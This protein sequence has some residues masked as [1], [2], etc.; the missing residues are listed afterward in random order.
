MTRE[1]QRKSDHIR[2]SDEEIH[3]MVEDANAREQ[4]EREER[5]KFLISVQSEGEFPAPVLAREYYDEAR[6]C[7]LYGAF[8]STILMSQLAIEELLKNHFRVSKGVKGCLRDE[9][10]VDD[11]YL[12]DLV[13][14][15]KEE[16]LIGK[17]EADD[18][19]QIRKT[20]RNPYTHVKDVTSP[21]DAKGKKNQS[22]NFFDQGLK[23]HNPDLSREL[24]GTSVIDEAQHVIT[25]LCNYFPVISSRL[26]GGG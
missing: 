13:E 6:L 20:Y 18:L 26:S 2:Y 3:S 17:E 14:E 16:G 15:A 5:L 21:R 23:I 19:D 4:S 10:T 12:F 9:K 7:W 25:L 1:M 24:L 11:S 8:V 22:G